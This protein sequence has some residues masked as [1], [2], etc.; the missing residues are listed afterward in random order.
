MSPITPGRAQPRDAFTL[1]EVLVVVGIIALLVAILLPS[2][3]NARE[4][5]KGSVCGSNMRHIMQ[6]GWTWMLEIRR[7]RVP[8]HRG[9]A[10][11]V[12]K[13]MHGETKPFM[14]PSVEDPIPISP[15]FITQGRTGFT[16]PT[17]SPDAAYFRHQT[18]P[19]AAGYFKAEMETE[20]DTA[21]GDSDFDDAYVY[22]KPLTDKTGDMY[23][24]KAG[25]GRD[26]SLFSWKGSLFEKNF[27][28]TAHYT[29]PMIYGG[30]AMNLSIAVPGLKP[31][32]V[33]YADYTEWSAC[34][35]PALRVT[36]RN[37]SV[38]GDKPKRAEW[39]DPRHNKR[40]NVG[41]LDSHVERLPEGRLIPP[42]NE[43][44]ASIW[45]P[46]RPAG[47]V[48]PKLDAVDAGGPKAP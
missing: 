20:S 38:R 14:C 26:L 27:G 37:G 11:Y 39:V 3:R 6:A 45:H 8:A 25:T 12:L 41:F 33:F 1:I 23:A 7:E 16:F 44:S 32:H 35:E 9:W 31:Q 4:S 48:P 46:A 24:V 5:A 34:T 18:R 40:V 13:A 29:Q 28:T 19:D 43:L 10:P 2:L 15:V 42:T 22:T 47:W 17:M 21:G 30:Y 36:G